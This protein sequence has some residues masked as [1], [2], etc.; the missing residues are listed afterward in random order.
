MTPWLGGWQNF[1]DMMIT[2][3]L[4]E[5]GTYQGLQSPRTHAAMAGIREQ[6]QGCVI[7]T[8]SWTNGPGWLQLAAM[9]DKNIFL[10]SCYKPVFSVP[11]SLISSLLWRSLSVQHLSIHQIQMGRRRRCVSVRCL[12]WPQWFHNAIVKH[13]LIANVISLSHTSI[14]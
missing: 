14:M 8:R 4:F 9:K 13:A 12:H 5:E 1:C 10:A 6:R 3:R 2:C 11:Q 7:K